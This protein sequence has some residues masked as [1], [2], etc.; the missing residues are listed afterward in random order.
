MTN[1]DKRKF[2]INEMYKMIHANSEDDLPSKKKIL[3]AEFCL[4]FGISRRQAA[5]YLGILIDAQRVEISNKEDLWVK[6]T[7]ILDGC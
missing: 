1:E 7:S 2:R 5:E 4:R 6:N 3:L